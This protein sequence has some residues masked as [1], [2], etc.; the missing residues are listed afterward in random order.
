MLAEMLNKNGNELI[1]QIKESSWIPKY[2]TKLIA[3][4][5][6]D[7]NSDHSKLKKQFEKI[8]RL[9][10]EGENVEEYKATLSAKYCAMK[11]S[12]RCVVSYLFHSIA[13]NREEI[14]AATRSKT[15]F[16]K[17]G[18]ICQTSQSKNCQQLKENIFQSTQR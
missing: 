9:E 11:Q 3:K 6:N 16:G 14:F 15:C 8:K 10:K 4:I 13:F 5:Q 2:N 18:I 1:E 7:L 12:I 17:S